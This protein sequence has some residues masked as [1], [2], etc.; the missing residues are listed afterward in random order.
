MCND[1]FISVTSKPIQ[2]RTRICESS[3]MFSG[4][5]ELYFWRSVRKLVR[6]YSKS[7]AYDGYHLGPEEL[8]VAINVGPFG[9]VF[10]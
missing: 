2:L 7:M 3:T 10:L 8:S 5:S 9:K 4:K 1:G 6:D